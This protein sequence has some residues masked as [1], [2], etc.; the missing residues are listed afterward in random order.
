LYELRS[1]PDWQALPVVIVTNVPAGEFQGSWQFLKN[2]LGV[3][4][5]HY[6]PLLSLRALRDMAEEYALV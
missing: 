4:S 2:E 1:Y 6:K 3:L 5:Y